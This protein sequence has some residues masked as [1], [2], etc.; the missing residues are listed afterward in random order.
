VRDYNIKM[1][2][3]YQSGAVA[4]GENVVKYEITD[5]P[6]QM[7]PTLNTYSRSSIV[8]Q[9]LFSGLYKLGP[10]GETY[11]PGCA[12]SYEVSEDGMTY[13]FKLKE[14]LTWSD[15]SALTA[16]DFEY[17][18]KRVLNPEVASGSASDLWVL[19][20]GK[21]YNE[22]TLT[23]DD[24]GV[25]AT[26]DLTLVVETSYY[27]PWF[28]TLTATTVFFPVKQD[29]VEATG[30]A[31]TKNVSTYVSNGPF[32]L[33]EYSSLDKLVMTKN[34]NYYDAANVKIDQVIY[35]IIAD[36]AA[37]LV[38]YDNDQLNVADDID[39]NAKNE[40]G[41]TDQYIASER[42]GIQYWDFNCKLPEFSDPRVRQAFSKSI[43]RK[44]VLAALS[45]TSEVPVY[46]FVPDSQPSLT[47]DGSYRSVAGDLFT[48]DVAAAQALLTEAGYEGGAGFPVVNIVCQNSDEQKLMAQILG[49]MWKSNLGIEYTI[50]T[51]ESSTY[52]DELA[53]GNFSV[54]R[55]GFTCDYLDPS[56]NLKIWVSGSNCSENGWDDTTYDD[57]VAAASQIIDPAA[58]EQALVEAETYLCDQMP[59]MP[60][61]TMTD[62]Y[63]VKSNLEGI[64]K[65]KIGHIYFEYAYFE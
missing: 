42:I 32:M 23:A 12:E 13:T 57:M 9:N 11:V 53:N 20:N 38:A 54:G 41:T 30:D 3:I 49:E 7:D 19:K 60:M 43:D 29:V 5:D 2:G 65:N 50:T 46:G 26:D 44:A 16:R 39:I 37:V 40:Y 15:G 34:P 25:K 18:W 58:R 1:P 21:E 33:T 6:Q 24:V 17:A 51:Y 28:V 35:Y 63:L 52:W 56:A 8:L 36:P 22:G 61:Y 47:T 45:L 48:E 14:G 59:G 64:V 27:A 31:W 10:D 62:D 55:N 4:E